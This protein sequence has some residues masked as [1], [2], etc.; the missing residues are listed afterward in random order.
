MTTT[1]SKQND[2]TK[3][4]PKGPF[5]D[6][7]ELIGSVERSQD[8]RGKE[9]LKITLAN[10]Q[11]TF[12]AFRTMEKILSNGKKS[13][14]GTSYHIIRFVEGEEPKLIGAVW[15]RD[16]AANAE[17]RK[18]DPMIAYDRL[19]IRIDGDTQ[20]YMAYASPD[21]ALVKNQ[22]LAGRAWYGTWKNGSP[23][24]S[25][26]FGAD[27]M[28]FSSVIKSGSLSARRYGEDTESAKITFI[29]SKPVNVTMK[30]ETY[31]VI[32][33]SSFIILPANIRTVKNRDLEIMSLNQ[34]DEST[35]LSSAAPSRKRSSL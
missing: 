9:M 29:D 1:Y 4:K 3:P 23:K 7:R 16:G 17:K 20:N 35:T 31:D 32:T 18:A 25:M 19:R 33:P 34:V 24:I 13:W 30:G 14:K 27:D 2:A 15:E 5:D 26:K 28:I 10:Y 6:P 22:Q 11:E 8:S 12:F 21:L